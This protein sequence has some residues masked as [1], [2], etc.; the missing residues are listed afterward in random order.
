MPRRDETP[1]VWPLL[2]TQPSV[3]GDVRVRETGIT[4]SAGSALLG[5]D[6]DG[7]RHL[8]V[9]LHPDEPLREDRTSR[10]VHIT[11]RTLLDG[12]RS[13]RFADVACRVTHLVELFD[14]LVDEMLDALERQPPSSPAACLAVLGRWRELLEH[15]R[16]PLLGVERLAA[17]LAE[18]WHLRGIVERDPA[19]RV[20]CWT[21]PRSDRHDLR[22]GSIALEVKAT[23]VREGLSVEIHGQEQLEPPEG[24]DLYL[25]VMRLERVDRDGLTVP[26]L[27]RELLDLGADRQQLIALL[28]RAGYRLSESGTYERM[29]FRVR[30]HRIYTVD[31]RFPKII[32]S[33]FLSGA[34]PTGILRLRYD[35]DLTGESPVP[36]PAHELDTILTRLAA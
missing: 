18:L 1:A 4:V 16:G 36:L 33:S 3:L 12:E 15:E 17:L 31:K 35:V 7:G 9:P 25:G 6:V 22:R 11:E 30:D 19:R 5:L 13:L 24:G 29:H 23:L 34:V 32:A 21:G 2:A 26:A 10:G 8:L 27:V 20:D 14:I 28:E